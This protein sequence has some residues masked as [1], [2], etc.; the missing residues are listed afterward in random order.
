MIRIGLWILIVVLVILGFYF[1]V[2]KKSNQLAAVSFLFAVVAF[3]IQ[4]I[5][6]SFDDISC[7]SDTV[8]T[9][10][11]QTT[12]H[13]E[14]GTTKNTTSAAQKNDETEAETSGS[15]EVEE[16]KNTETDS[17][18][19]RNNNVITND[20]DL[21]G[22]FSNAS[23]EKYILRTK[24]TNSYGLK[25]HISDVNQSYSVTIM[26]EKGETLYE[27]YINEDEITKDPLLEKNVDY[28]LLV[29]A[30]EGNPEYKI[31]VRYP[32]NDIY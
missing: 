26:D 6:E 21:R 32:D 22:T 10:Q 2:V 24:Y 1:I 28:T 11:Y 9:T 18:S 14:K 30:D 20:S 4:S 23:I 19:L 16:P 29:E 31:E 5:P 12:Y 15:T 17:S 3:L 7:V 13:T 8:E 25:F 27:Y